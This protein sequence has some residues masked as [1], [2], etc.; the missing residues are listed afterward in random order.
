MGGG[1]GRK[2]ERR[3]RGKGWDGKATAVPI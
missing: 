2:R 1:E 3:L